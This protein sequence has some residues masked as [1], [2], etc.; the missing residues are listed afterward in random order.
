MQY[1]RIN[2]IILLFLIII[3]ST[4]CKK[5]NDNSKNE[6]IN[7]PIT[8][9]NEKVFEDDML[10]FNQ[11]YKQALFAIKENKKE[12]AIKLTRES[13]EKW[14]KIVKKYASK[15]PN[16]Y[17]KT[18]EWIALLKEIEKNQEESLEALLKNE[19]NI[20]YEKL[21]TV[22]RKIKQLREENGIKN[23][24]NDILIFS[25]ILDKII[26]SD[27]KQEIDLYLGELKINFTILKEYNQN[28]EK[29]KEMIKDL[30]NVIVEIEHLGEKNFNELKSKLNSTFTALYLQFG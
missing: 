13:Y 24:S 7:E 8:E 10:D 16:Q 30:E 21:E 27:S 19:I 28:N 23:I 26:E 6:L 25:F 17:R 15:Q 4:A 3:S 18:K 9:K 11:I 12:N 22:R 2:I 20:A 1:K 14:K 5:D 29:Y